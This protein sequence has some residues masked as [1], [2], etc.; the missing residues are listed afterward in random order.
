[1]GEVDW[2]DKL[3]EKELDSCLCRNDGSKT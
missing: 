1:M 2:M 3:D